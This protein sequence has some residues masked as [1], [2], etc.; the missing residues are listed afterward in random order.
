[1]Y[2]HTLLYI[3]TC[4]RTMHV[5]MSS[6]NVCMCVKAY[7]DTYVQAYVHACTKLNSTYIYALMYAY[8]GV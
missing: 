8:E 4:I 3:C 1:M 2:M 7:V 5:Y 6:I